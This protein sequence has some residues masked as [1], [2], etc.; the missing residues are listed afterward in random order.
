MLSV[1]IKLNILSRKCF[2]SVTYNSYIGQ[3]LCDA[4][5]NVLKS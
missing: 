1:F 3:S 2:S 4:T 5:V